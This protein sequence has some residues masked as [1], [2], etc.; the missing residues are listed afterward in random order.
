MQVEYVHA[1]MAAL[2][3]VK[4][5]Q[6]Q[7]AAMLFYELPPWRNLVPHQQGED[8]ACFNCIMN[9]EPPQSSSFWV[10]CGG[11]KL[12][13]HHLSKTLHAHPTSAAHTPLA[14]VSCGAKPVYDL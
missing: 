12:I 9:S 10:H 11:P 4:I 8:A 7:A 5:L 14:A 13:R 1:A 6:H 2:S 3:Y